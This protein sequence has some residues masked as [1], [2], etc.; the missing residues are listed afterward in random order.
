M[1]KKLKS[2]P[3][4]TFSV[5][6]VNGTAAATVQGRGVLAESLL[7][8][9]VCPAQLWLLTED[10]IKLHLFHSGLYTLR[11]DRISGTWRIIHLDNFFKSLENTLIFISIASEWFW[12]NSVR[13]MKRAVLWGPLL[14]I[15]IKLVGKRTTNYCFALT[16]YGPSNPIRTFL[17]LITE[18]LESTRRILP[19]PFYIWL[20]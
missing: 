3:K 19:F 18:P 13:R 20:S 12:V 11:W 9:P 14:R 6:T 5:M 15:N 16:L 4:A 1:T 17:C 2:F 10:K 7:L 8:P